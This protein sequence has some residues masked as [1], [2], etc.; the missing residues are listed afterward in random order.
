VGYATTK[1]VHQK[2]EMV[3][4]SHKQVCRDLGIKPCQLRKWQKDID[5]IRSLHKG[6]MKANKL[7]HPTQFLILEDRLH[8]LIL[9]KWKLRRKVRENWI[10]C[11]ARLEFESLW[12]ERVTIVERETSL[13][14]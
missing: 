8:T 4:I 6:T 2:G 11:Y 5:K 1:R 10:H 12:L 13:L 14:E 7:S 9:E 3:L